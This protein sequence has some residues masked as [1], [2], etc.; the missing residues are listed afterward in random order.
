[1]KNKTTEQLSKIWE[2]AFWDALGRGCTEDEASKEAN[3]K[4]GR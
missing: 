2:R 1:M 3:K 4:I